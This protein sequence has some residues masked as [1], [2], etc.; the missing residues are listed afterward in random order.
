MHAQP[1]FVPMGV[2]AWH[3][4]VHAHRMHTPA[5]L[6][7]DAVEG[8]LLANPLPGA[9]GPGGHCNIA[10]KRY[11]SWFAGSCCLALLPVAWAQMGSGP[12]PSYII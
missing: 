8:Q 6:R 7:G 5:Q 12:I 9:E 1:L 2:H 11:C 4:A 3:S 10:V